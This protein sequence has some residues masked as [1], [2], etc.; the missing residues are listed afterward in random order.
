MALPARGLS[1]LGGRLGR[2]PAGAR[3]QAGPA[4]RGFRSSGVR[5]SREKRFHLPEVST[6]CLP[7]CPHPQPAF[8]FFF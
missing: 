1:L 6:V 4:S 2:V 7:T 3:G 5:T 8:F